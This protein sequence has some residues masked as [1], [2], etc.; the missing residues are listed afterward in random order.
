MEELEEEAKEKIETKEDKKATQKQRKQQKKEERKRSKGWKI[1]KIIIILLAITTLI[2]GGIFTYRMAKN[3]WGLQGFIATAVGHDE[4]TL[5]NLDKIT[6]MVIGISGYEENYKL[7]DTI[8]VCSYDPKTQQASMLSIPRDTYVG[9]DKTKASASYKINSVYRNGKN[10]DGMIEEVEKITGLTIPNYVVVDTSALIQLVDAIGGVDYEVPIAMEYDDT[11]Q[12]LHID[13][14]AGMQHLNGQQA[15]WLVRFRHNND[16]SSY[17]LE[18]GDNDLGRMRTQREFIKATMHQ[19]LKPENLLKLNKIAEI[20]YSNIKTNMTFNSIKDYLPYSV[21]FK[22]DNLK[23]GVLP[24]VAETC[25]KVAIYSINKKE[26]KD[27]VA[28]LFETGEEEQETNTITN[29]VNTIKNSK[30]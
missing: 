26:A 19:T 15:E 29:S 3:G 13:L 16:G 10:I 12:D 18:Y 5:K 21:N 23:T 2:L 17:P 30:K 14:E 7:A 4:N 8:M 6:F 1:F 24:G 28:E 20:G 11:T 25:N 22:I 27:L 9:K